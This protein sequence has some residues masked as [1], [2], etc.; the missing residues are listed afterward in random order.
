MQKL[1]LFCLLALLTGG[2][3]AQPIFVDQFDDGTV[4]PDTDKFDVTEADGEM[5]VTGNGTNG[6]WDGVWYQLPQNFDVTASPKLFVRA[7]SSIL[8][9]SLRMDLADGTNF[10]NVAPISQTLTNE[11][12]VLEYDFSTVDVGDMDL[13]AVTAIFFF[14]DGGTAGFTGQVAIDYFALGEEPEGTIMSDVYQDHMDSDS[15]ITNWVNEVVGFTRVRTTGPDADSTIVQ[16]VGDGTAG[17]W[18]PHVYALRP[19]PEYIQTSVDISDNPKLFIKAK[20]SVP[21]TSFR[22]DVQDTDNISSI[23][24]AVTRILTEEWTVYEYDY[25]DAFQNFENEACPAAMT[26]PCDVNLEAIKE[27]LLYVDGGTGMFAGTI[28]I[29]WISFDVSLDGEGP[30]AEL[31][32]SDQF[33]NDLVS[34]TGCS[35]GLEVS[36]MDGNLIITGDGTSGMFGT[37]SY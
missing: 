27:L 17:P 8:G 6:A 35:D 16:L 29:D 21:G 26:D 4:T 28:D 1:L 5:L 24:N 34:W 30:A 22:I 2:L 11:Y 23:G 14:I 10:T 36:E 37:V 3:V 25:T 7:K 15:S 31:M 13:T 33:D 18:T 9:T 20:T 19:P 32:Y 12:R